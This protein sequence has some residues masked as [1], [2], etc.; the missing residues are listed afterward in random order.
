MKERIMLV[1]ALLSL[2]AGCAAGAAYQPG[3]EA[4][5]EPYISDVPPSF[6]NGNPALRDWYTAPYW[7]PSVGP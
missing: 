7:D 4:P 6:Y 5:Y 3:R 2:L 1:L